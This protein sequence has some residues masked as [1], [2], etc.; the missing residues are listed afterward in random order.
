MQI[1]RYIFRYIFAYNEK[2]QM[3]C[4]FLKVN[5]MNAF[6]Y[7]LIKC[8]FYLLR[9]FYW[10][11]YVVYN[12]KCYVFWLQYYI[13]KGCQH[14]CQH[15]SQSPHLKLNIM[16]CYWLENLHF[17]ANLYRA[18]FSLLLTLLYNQKHMDNSGILLIDFV[19]YNFNYI[20]LHS[21]N[22]SVLTITYS[23]IKRNFVRWNYLF[24]KR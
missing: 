24:I 4:T 22:I 17:F 6:G 19:L 12:C 5:L 3:N 10:Y 18:V 8:L 21:C 20:S 2:F 23:F 11:I 13:Y 9:K 15:E 16:S 14:I 7:E 1:L